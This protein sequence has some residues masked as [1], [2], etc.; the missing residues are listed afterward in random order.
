[1]LIAGRV[2]ESVTIEC[3]SVRPN[4][5]VNNV[6]RVYRPE[7]DAFEGFENSAEATGRLERVNSGS[8]TTYSFGPLRDSDNGTILICTSSGESS[9]NATIIVSCKLLCCL[10]YTSP[11][12]RDATLSRMPSSA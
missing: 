4:E 2:G 1:M 7:Q 10:L 3:T 11:S 9:G 8:L 12:P 5:A 6:L